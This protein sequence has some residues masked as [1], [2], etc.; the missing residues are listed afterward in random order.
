[1]SAIACFNNNIKGFVLFEHHHNVCKVTIKL[2]NFL[3]NR[4]HA[5]HIHE[6]GDMRYGCKSAGG[7]YNPHNKNHGSIFINK[8]NRHVGDLINN[9]KSDNNGNVDIC[10]LDNLV[11]INGKNSIIGRSVVIHDGIDD[12]GRWN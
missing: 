4:T 12:C 11:K 8:N 1:M 7:H 6:Y 2:K 5:I 10:Y 9:I 3:P